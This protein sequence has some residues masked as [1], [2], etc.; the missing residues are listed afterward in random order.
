M[1]NNQSNS[2]LG[3]RNREQWELDPTLQ[4]HNL[5]ENSLNKLVEEEEKFL[6]SMTYDER[7]EYYDLA[8]DKSWQEVKNDNSN[9]PKGYFDV[10]GPA[11]SSLIH[12]NSNS[13]N[14][15]REAY[16]RDSWLEFPSGFV[17]RTFLSGERI[18]DVPMLDRNLREHNLRTHQRQY[19]GGA[20]I[21][22]HYAL[23]R[24][25]PT[26]GETIPYLP[27]HRRTL[28]RPHHL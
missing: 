21:H 14:P 19:R 17:G 4:L 11:P 27:R 20:N 25:H 24:Q 18:L 6:R 2:S 7:T 13:T 1:S 3:R 9:L 23:Q 28:P 15:Y 8:S 5:Y 26:T 22:P 12:D 10:F 16:V